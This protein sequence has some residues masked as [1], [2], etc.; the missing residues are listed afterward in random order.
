MAVVPS[1][2]PMALCILVILIL[3]CLSQREIGFEEGFEGRWGYMCHCAW[4]LGQ[5]QL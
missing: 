1:A 4:V 5:R 3:W 2:S